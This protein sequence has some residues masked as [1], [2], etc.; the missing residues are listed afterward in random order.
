MSSSNEPV[1]VTLDRTLVRYEFVSVHKFV[2][3]SG[4][5]DREDKQD[6]EDTHR[7]LRDQQDRE[8]THRFLRD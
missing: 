7:F 1:L 6:R 4:E 2:G 5:Q 3:L 8:D